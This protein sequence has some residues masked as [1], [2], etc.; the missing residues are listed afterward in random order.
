MGVVLPSG[1]AVLE[2]LSRWPTV[3]L[4]D[5]VEEIIRIHGHG[6]RTVLR[7]GVPGPQAVAG[8]QP[9][10]PGRGSPWGSLGAWIRRLVARR[11]PPTAPAP[12]PDRTS[13]PV[14]PASR[15]P[16]AP[17]RPRRWNARAAGG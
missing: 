17:V 12:A 9:V 3:T 11:V 1:R 6:G 4:F 14:S 13:P 5:S 15:K 7:W 10:A 16:A 8:P 2:W